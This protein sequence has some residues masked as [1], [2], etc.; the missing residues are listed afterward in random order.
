MD[1]KTVLQGDIWTVR[2]DPTE[3]S[4][5]KKTRPCL[6]ISRSKIN[7]KLKTITI[8]PFS[9]GKTN[10][11]ILSINIDSSKHNGLRKDSHL[12][13]HQIRT[14]GKHRLIKKTGI[15]EGEYVPR[16]KNSFRLYFWE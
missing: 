7:K 15:L 6:V 3:G 14:V 9:T 11:S 10:K 13:I 12:V 1:A 16:L 4:E 8:I 5:L 2:L